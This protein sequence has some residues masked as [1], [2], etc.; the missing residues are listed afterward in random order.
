MLTRCCGAPDGTPLRPPT[1]T[2]W[3]TKA[4]QRLVNP[5]DEEGPIPS[6]FPAVAAHELR[7]TAL[8]LMIRS[9]AHVKTV[10]RQLGPKSAVMTLDLYGRLFDDDLDSIADRMGDGLRH[11]RETRRVQDALLGPIRTPSTSK[12]SPPPA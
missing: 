12:K 8:S 11:T 4:V 5:K 2:H 3:F 1:T 6:T 7:H 9:G 10:Q